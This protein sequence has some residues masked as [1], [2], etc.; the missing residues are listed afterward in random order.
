MPAEK[1]DFVDRDF[2]L[3]IFDMDGTLVQSEECASQA[4]KDVIPLMTDSVNE[5]TARYKGMRLA[6]IF[7]DIESRFPNSVPYNCLDLFVAREEALSQSYIIPSEGADELLSRLQ[8]PKCIASN[9]PVEKSVRSL[10][11]CGI[12]HH[13]PTAI[14]SADRVNAWKPDPTLFL[15]AANFHGIEPSKCLVLEDSRVGI[16]AALSARMSVIHYDPTDGGSTLSVP[17]IA[18]L[19]DLLNYVK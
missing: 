12:S 6:E 13:F 14:F 11:I 19:V 1:N 4:L 16:Q 18:S 10:S 5:V 2:Q 9:A 15:H 8:T 17:S 3:V 7:D